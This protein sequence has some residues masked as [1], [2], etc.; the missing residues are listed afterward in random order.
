MVL[1]YPTQTQTYLFVYNEKKIIGCLIAEPVRQVSNSQ[2]R[3]N[4]KVDLNSFLKLLVT[5]KEG[6]QSNGF[7]LS[8]S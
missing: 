3:V 5:A 7:D 6:E 8:V 2:H 4:S 1:T